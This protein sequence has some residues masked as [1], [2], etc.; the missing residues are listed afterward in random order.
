MQLG[1]PDNDV[2]MVDAFEVGAAATLASVAAAAADANTGQQRGWEMIQRD[3]VRDGAHPMCRYVLR[4][5]LQVQTRG[6]A[7][8]ST[9]QAVIGIGGASCASIEFKASSP[10]D[11]MEEEEHTSHASTGSAELLQMLLRPFF[12]PSVR[13]TLS[14]RRRS[15][16]GAPKLV[17]R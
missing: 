8:H 5:V 4:V 2:V 6:N 3:T 12:A 11:R 7:G 17:L 14:S 15:G 9:I 13:M 1:A 10:T 16:S